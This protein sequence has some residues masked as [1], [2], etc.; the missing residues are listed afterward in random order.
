[1]DGLILLIGGLLAIWFVPVIV[2]L[3]MGLSNL[4]SNPKKGKNLLIAAFVYLLVG[5]G[6][7]GSMVG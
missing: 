1:M 5:A 7:C 2:M 3:I 6:I 4:K